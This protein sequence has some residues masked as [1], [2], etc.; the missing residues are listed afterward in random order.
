MHMQKHLLLCSALALCA[1]GTS[2]AKVKIWVENHTKDSLNIRWTSKGRAGVEYHGAC[3][4]LVEEVKPGKTRWGDDASAAIRL[5]S[6]KINGHKIKVDKKGHYWYLLVSTSHNSSKKKTTIHYSLHHVKRTDM[7]KSKLKGVAGVF[8]G[9]VESKVSAGL[10][11]PDQSDIE[12]A[13]AK[14]GDYISKSVVR[15]DIEL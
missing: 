1:V 12:D 15:G 5:E 6:I 3:P 8:A 11:G 2:T 9:V 7:L 4:S 10:L 14:A 13:A